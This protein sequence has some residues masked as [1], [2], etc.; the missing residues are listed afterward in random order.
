MVYAMWELWK[1]FRIE[2]QSLGRWKLRDVPIEQA[3][4]KN[5]GDCTT[6]MSIA[7]GFQVF[8]C[9]PA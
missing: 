5:S 1:V 9:D 2:G 4:R 3:A 7:G 8:A 6:K